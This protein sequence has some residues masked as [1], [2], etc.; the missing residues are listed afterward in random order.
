MTGIDWLILGAVV[1][2]ALFGWAQGF[3]AGVL[4][5]VGHVPGAERDARDQAR[6]GRGRERRE[7][8]GVG[9]RMPSSPGA[10][11]G[12]TAAQCQGS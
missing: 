3:V 4:A 1:L 12:P 9:D 8:A 11:A 7:A 10:R 5:L 2:L 6:E